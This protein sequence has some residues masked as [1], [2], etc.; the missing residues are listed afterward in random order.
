[1]R[2][3]SVRTQVITGRRPRRS[4]VAAAIV[5][6]AALTAL[7][8]VTAGAV[9]KSASGKFTSTQ[10]TGADC[11][12]PVGLCWRGSLSGGLKGPFE[13]TATSLTQTADTPTTGV[14]LY[15]GD[16]TIELKDGTLTCKDAGA[17]RTTGAGDVASVCAVVSGK[18]SFAG[19][20][21]A[22]RLSGTFM[23][24]VGQGDFTATLD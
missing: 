2:E 20:T 6:I 19:T 13:F 24:G 1:M 11:T 18:G 22:I 23:A 16:M 4:L 3:K 7:F 17:L 8:G 14:V 9:T 10:V 21:G 12:S 15:T 5:T